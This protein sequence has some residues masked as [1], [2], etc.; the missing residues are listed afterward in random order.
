MIYEIDLLGFETDAELPP[1]C[2][3]ACPFEV[4][5]IKR[6]VG[7]VKAHVEVPGI[8][9]VIRSHTPGT[10]GNGSYYTLYYYLASVLLAVLV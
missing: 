8:A 4:T 7:N 3:H 9:S 6:A 10:E 2:P 5:S 1:P